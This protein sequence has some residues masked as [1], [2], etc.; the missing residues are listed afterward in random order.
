[1]L[2]STA[3]DESCTATCQGSLVFQSAPPRVWFLLM[4]VLW[5]LRPQAP[6]LTFWYISSW[7]TSSRDLIEFRH[8]SFSTVHNI[9]QVRFC[10]WTLQP[11]VSLYVL[12]FFLAIMQNHRHLLVLII[13]WDREP[14]QAY[15]SLS[16]TPYVLSDGIN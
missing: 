11:F 13:S 1:M 12:R 9:Q 7:S 4:Q 5:H 2:V 15:L 3:S 14:F 8:F 16:F 10:L 6:D